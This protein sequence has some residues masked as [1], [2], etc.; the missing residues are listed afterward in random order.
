MQ[1]YSNS[2]FVITDNDYTCARACNTGFLLFFFMCV[3][4]PCWLM[5]PTM[6][7]KAILLTQ[8][9]MFE[10]DNP[11]SHIFTLLFMFLL[12]FK[13]SLCYISICSFSKTCRN[14]V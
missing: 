2:S 12:V 13:G 10:T 8:H 14:N 7:L 4:V 5:G 3:C 11:V 1:K 6:A 9:I